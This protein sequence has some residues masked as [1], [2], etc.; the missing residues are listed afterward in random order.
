VVP[1]GTFARDN[2]P[3]YPA[4]ISDLRLD[5]YEVT[6]GRFRRF[7]AGYPGNLPRPGSGKNPNNP[8]DPGWDPSWDTALEM[9]RA[10]LQAR[11]RCGYGATWTDLPSS[12]EALPISCITWYEAMAFCVWDGGRLATEAEWNYAAAGGSEQRI[13][14]WSKPPDSTLIDPSYAAYRDATI[15]DAPIG[16]VGSKSKGNGRWGHADLAGNVF[17]WVADNPRGGY[18]T[19]CT[20]CAFF[21]DSETYRRDLGGSWTSPHSMLET[22]YRGLVVSSNFANNIGTRCARPL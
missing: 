21:L 9:D 19:P 15:G 17:E 7:L 13:F 4:T 3:D 14:P 8:A 18:V 2:D 20:D 5:T 22:S 12:A 1:G 16:R 11:L 10:K 6:V